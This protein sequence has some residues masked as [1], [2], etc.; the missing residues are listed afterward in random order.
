MARANVSLSQAIAELNREYSQL[1]KWI[2]DYLKKRAGWMILRPLKL[3]LYNYG[4]DGAGNKLPPYKS[5]AYVRYKRSKGVRGRPTTLFLTGSFYDSMEVITGKSGKTHLIEVVTNRSAKNE[6]KK[7]RELKAK[8]GSDILTLNQDEAQDIAD[9]LSKVLK[10][11][12][13]LNINIELS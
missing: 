1:G 4:T 3:R 2:P 12:F 11:K 7:T 9:E 6:P 10:E 13:E 8:Y 5:E